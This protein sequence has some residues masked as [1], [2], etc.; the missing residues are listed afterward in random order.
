[1]ERKFFLKDGYWQIRLSDDTKWIT[2]FIYKGQ[3][4]TC[5]V[6]PF[7]LSYAPMIFQEIMRKVF[8]GL[9]FVLIYLDDILIASED[10]QTHLK[11]MD[12]VLQRV[13]DYNMILNLKKC[14]FC[15]NNVNILGYHVDSDGISMQ[16]KHTEKL[17]TLKQPTTVKELRSLLGFLNYFRQHVPQ[18]AK[19]L[20][21]IQV[22]KYIG[23]LK[24]IKLYNLL[25]VYN[26]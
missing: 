10:D 11:H 23:L 20:S 2:S 6:L 17:P 4:Y 18:L 21:P 15:V 25:I 19:L 24:L 13:N 8:E 12:Q 16:T 5:D 14:Q 3:V 26:I 7:G 1:M 9:D 22:T